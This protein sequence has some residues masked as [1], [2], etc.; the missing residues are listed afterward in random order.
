MEQMMSG[1]GS[2]IETRFLKCQIM[3][4]R[5]RERERE[6]ERECVCVCVCV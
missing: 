2:R 4:H 5:K 3:K 1:S 6:R